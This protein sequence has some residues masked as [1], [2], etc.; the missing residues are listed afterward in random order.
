MR[1]EP[2]PAPPPARASVGYNAWLLAVGTVAARVAMFGLGIVLARF[3]GP[4]GYGAYALA[5]AIGFVLQPIAD[6][7]LTPYLARETARSRAATEAALPTIMGAKTVMIGLTYV[8]TLA[9]TAAF[10]DDAELLA[11]IAVVVLSVLIDGYSGLGFAYFQG[12]EVMAYEAKLTATMAI[13]RALGSIALAVTFERL[14]PVVAWTLFVALLQAILTLRRLGGAIDGPTCC[15]PA[16]V[17][18]GALAQCRGRGADGHLRDGVPADRLRPA[19]RDRRRGGGRDLRRGVHADDGRPDRA[20]DARHGAH[21]VFARTHE[22]EPEKFE[23]SWHDGVQGALLI[24]LPVALVTS[25]LAG[26]IIAR[27]YGAEFAD[28]AVVLAIIIWICPLGALSLVAQAVLRGAR[29]EAFLTGVSG[30]CALLNLLANLWAIPRHGVLGASWVTVGTEVLNVLVLAG[31]V[32]RLGLVPRP[33]FPWL[34]AGLSLSA[35]TAVV[36]VLDEVPVE[37]AVAAGLAAPCRG[38][39]RHGGDGR[40][41]AVLA[42][43]RRDGRE[44]PSRTVSHDGSRRSGRRP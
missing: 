35:A 19:R 23:R 12:R 13:V 10:V 9:I 41:G 28:S 33:I 17:G 42:R 31:I 7:G 11:V 21:T 40:L 6:L 5:L 1:A 44:R 30:A 2:A 43:V 32:I 38:A 24:A 18:A 15:A 8:V 34:R 39:H 16:P 29:R 37:L 36:T 22:R 25:L 26:P 20:G 4:E 14:G 27:F 3:L